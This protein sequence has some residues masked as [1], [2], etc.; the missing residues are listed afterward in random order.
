MLLEYAP[1]TNKKNEIKKKTETVSKRWFCIV[2]KFAPCFHSG[3]TDRFTKST[4]TIVSLT[5]VCYVIQLEVCG[6]HSTTCRTLQLY[7]TP[8]VI[9]QCKLWHMSSSLINGLAKSKHLLWFQ[10]FERNVYMYLTVMRS[11]ML[12]DCVCFTRN[13][14]Y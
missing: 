9:G 1:H 3:N 11:E 8:D 2:L 13:P 10:Y 5:V 14:K 4:C 7:V 6:W 12:K